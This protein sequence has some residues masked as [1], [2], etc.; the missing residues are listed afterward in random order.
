MNCHSSLKVFL[1]VLR[2]LQTFGTR[3]FINQTP[4]KM[5]CETSS[6]CAATKTRTMCSRP[7]DSL[8][9][10]GGRVQ[11][12]PNIFIERVFCQVTSSSSCSCV[13]LEDDQEMFLR[14]NCVSRKHINRIKTDINLLSFVSCVIDQLENGNMSVWSPSP[15]T[16]QSATGGKSIKKR[17]EPEGTWWL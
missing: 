11:W 13:L 1:Q 12:K 7:S 5:C 9:H 17:A 16:S 6:I 2:S 8:E 3:R 4:I 14:S 10:L 15:L